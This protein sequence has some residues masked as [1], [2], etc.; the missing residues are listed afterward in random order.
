MAKLEDQV[1]GVHIRYTLLLLPLGK[2]VRVGNASMLT[3]FGMP[4]YKRCGDASWLIGICYQAGDGWALTAEGWR[5]RPLWKVVVNSILRT[6]QFWTS[7]R[8]LVATDSEQLDGINCSPM[9]LGYRLCRVEMK[10]AGYAS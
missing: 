5:H 10:E 2:Y 9:T 4:V 6:A 3:V 7:R 1:I 8:L